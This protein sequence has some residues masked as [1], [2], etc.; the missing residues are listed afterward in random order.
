MADLI[1]A[2]SA[3]SARHTLSRWGVTAVDHRP[4]KAGRLQALYDA[5]QV[6]AAQRSRPG[7]GRRTGAT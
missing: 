4:S 6:R 7:R 2:A 3:G 5:D 1:G